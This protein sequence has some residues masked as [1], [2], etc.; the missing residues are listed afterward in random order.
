[1]LVEE[2]AFGACCTF[3]GS[4]LKCYK[5]NSLI[6][7]HQVWD[8]DI[9]LWTWNQLFHCCWP[10]ILARR[11]DATVLKH[12]STPRFR[13]SEEELQQLPLRYNSHTSLSLFT[14]DRIIN[15]FWESFWIYRVEHE[16]AYMKHVKQ[17]TKIEPC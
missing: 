16:N 12:T 11:R 14:S 3:T 7:S 13:P 15:T 4:N 10:E 5:L 6:L 17:L 1:M 8:E 2:S 9:D